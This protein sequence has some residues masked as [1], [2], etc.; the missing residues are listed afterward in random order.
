MPRVLIADKLETAGIELLKQAGLEVDNRPG[1]KGDDLKAALQGADAVIC[2]S[3]PKVT[4]EYLEN[5]GKLRAIARAGVGVDT[6]DVAAATRKGIVVMNTPSGNTVSAAEHTIAL[7]FALARQVPAADATM[8]AGGWDRNK[9]LGTQLAGKTLG[10]V[11]LGRIGQEVARRAKGLDM[12]VVGFDPFV[13]S[14]KTAEMGFKPAASIAD[15]L[16]KVDFLTLH[17]PLTPETKG[18]IGAKELASMKKTARVLNV[19]RGGVIDE[20]ALADALKAGTIA[21][22]GIDVF[23]VEPAAADNPLRSAPNVVLT[24]H[25]G[26]STAEAQ[27]NVAI[28]A[29]QLIADF[30]LKGIVAN[31]VNM[32]AVD[33][34]ELDEL[35]QYVDLARRLGLLQAQ[36]AKGPIKKASL[37]Y[38]GELAGKKTK[39]LTSAFTAGLL[40]GALAD[41][42]NLVNAGVSARDRGIEITESANPKKGDFAGVLHTEVETDDG[43]N[44]AAGTLFGDQYQRLVQLG[45]YRM[46]SFLDGTLLAFKHTDAPGLIGF[47]GGVFGRH[48]VNIAAMTVG[49]TGHAPGGQAIGVLNLDSVPS[50]EALAEAKA[51]PQITSVRV[52]KL[53]K[54]GELPPWLG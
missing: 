42:V 40:E 35:R 51:H 32:A 29:A 31:A 14:V 48:G 22:A 19:A 1:L 47:I 16:P 23:A 50:E 25:L 38:K 37:T 44:V 54:A 18:V 34:K 3:Q 20:Q 33:R 45:P 41:G 52:V 4:A 15:L 26:A 9:F 36:L 49:R 24:P 2:R 43:S 30:L 27:E 12:E 46:E 8:K 13:T 5:P 17:I 39:L 10:V 6:I 7:M 53:P 21:G 28:E 11:G